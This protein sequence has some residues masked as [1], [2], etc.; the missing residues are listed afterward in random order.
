MNRG[1]LARMQATKSIM[2]HGVPL[3]SPG[4]SG[5][6]WPL[7]FVLCLAG[8][9]LVLFHAS[10]DP[11]KV[12]FSND[13]PLGAQVAEYS[14]SPEGFSGV[15]QDLNWL[16]KEGGSFVP[17]ITEGLLWLLGPVGFAK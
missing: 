13:G 1:S 2:A 4:R 12:L 8:L 7:L 10:F 11:D 9:L 6:K 15:W 5:S 17:N 16:G 14:R 3:A